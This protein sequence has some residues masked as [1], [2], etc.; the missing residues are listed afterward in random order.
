MS[1]ALLLPTAESHLMPTVSWAALE[2]RWQQGEGSDCPTLICPSEPHIQYCIQAC[3]LQH[4][5]DVRLLK[6][7][8]RRP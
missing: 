4:K 3:G 5:K 2:E 1:S 7:A 6:R 8:Q